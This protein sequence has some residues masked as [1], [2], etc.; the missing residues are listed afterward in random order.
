LDCRTQR[1]YDSINGQPILLN[2]E[3]LSSILRLVK[4]V[5]FHRNKNYPLIIISPTLV[6][7]F[8]LAEELQEYLA[9]KSSVYKWI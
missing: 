8:E 1:G 3:G 7:G 4:S 6:F 9:S 2:D 5:K